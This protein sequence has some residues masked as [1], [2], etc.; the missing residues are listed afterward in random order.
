[1]SVP[2]STTVLRALI[3]PNDG[4]ALMCRGTLTLINDLSSSLVGKSRQLTLNATVDTN[5]MER[6]SHDDGKSQ[7]RVLSLKG[8]A[9]LVSPVLN[10]QQPLSVKLCTLPAKLSLFSG[11]IKLWPLR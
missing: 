1:M 3:D 10:L 8:N 11:E 7:E 4:F 9:G 5:E 2:V 6:L